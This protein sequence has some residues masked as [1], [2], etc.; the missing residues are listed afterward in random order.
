MIRFIDCHLP[1]HELIGDRVR[2]QP[3]GNAHVFDIALAGMVA[4]IELQ[5]LTP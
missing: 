2:L 5:K 4:T 1:T 3:C